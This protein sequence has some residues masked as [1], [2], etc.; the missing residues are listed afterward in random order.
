MIV[1]IRYMRPE[2]RYMGIRRY[3]RVQISLVPF[4]IFL[5]QCNHFG[6]RRPKGYLTHTAHRQVIA[7]QWVI[8]VVRKLAAKV[9]KLAAKVRKLAAKAKANRKM[10]KARANRKMAKARAAIVVPG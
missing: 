3:T 4:N 10:A 5:G 6:S 9:K 7:I 2:I 1:S 8:P